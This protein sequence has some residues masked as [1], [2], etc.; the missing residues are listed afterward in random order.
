MPATQTVQT[1][2]DPVQPASQRHKVELA[3]PRF[4]SAFTHSRHSVLSSAEYVPY[5][6]SLHVSCVYELTR[7]EYLPTAQSLQ[8]ADP[9]LVLY[10]PATHPVQTPSVP[11]QP[12]LQIHDIILTLP[13]GASAFTHS[14]HCVVVLYAEYSS[15][16]ELTGTEYFP[17]S[18][19]LHTIDPLMRL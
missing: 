17:A 9:V 11:V 18:H 16:E 7:M 8:T 12:A 5:A 3:I 13:A 19:I 6:Q 15:V 4:E 1:P 2:C 10:L 14:R